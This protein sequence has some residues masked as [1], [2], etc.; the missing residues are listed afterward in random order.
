MP[1]V[2]ATLAVSVLALL[3]GCPVVNDTALTS[4]IDSLDSLSIQALRNRDY[5]SV[6]EVVDQ[7][8][9]GQR[10]VL[11]ATYQ[12]DGLGVYSRIDIPE[13]PAGEDGYP[14]VIFVHGWMGI[15]AA[16]SANFYLDDDS[17]YDAMIRHFVDAGFVVF[18]PGWRGHG[19]VNGRPANSSAIRATFR[20][21]SPA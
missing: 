21:S 9:T 7:P 20:L 8:D 1:K 6:L 5:G 15:E 13:T 19:T 3:A 11:I 4:G 14:V 12:S 2:I 17:N 10:N 16:P 18:M